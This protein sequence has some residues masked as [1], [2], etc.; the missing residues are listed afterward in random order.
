LPQRLAAL[1]RWLERELAQSVALEPASSDASFRAYYRVYAGEDTYIAMD[2]PPDREDSRSFVSLSRM[3][4]EAGLNVPQVIA[5]DLEQGFLLL[6]DLGRRLYLHALCRDNVSRLYGDALGALVVIQACAPRSHTWPDYDRELL[7]REMGI[8]SEWL[9]RRHLGLVPDRRQQQMLDTCFSVLA[10]SALAQPR[11]CVHRDYH[12]RN[13]L[14]TAQ[15]NPGILDFQDAV[16]GPVTYDLVSL[17]RDCYI[18]WSPDEVE[19]WALGYRELAL[20]SGILRND[21]ADEHQFLR[22]FDWMGVQRHLKAAGIFARLLHRDGK[23]GYLADIP[24]TLRY[25]VDV[26]GRYG[27]L[28]PLYEFIARRVLPMMEQPRDRPGLPAAD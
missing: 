5:R 3:F 8:F 23:A 21:A 13:L 17:L 20:Q 19:D 7:M 22:W 27:E 15:N 26:A 25:V 9:L 24:R 18:R 12:S 1:T 28:A 4:A 10:E 6:T 2:A 14:V 16:S 11:V